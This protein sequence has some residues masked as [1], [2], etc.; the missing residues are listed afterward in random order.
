MIRLV[1]PYPISANEFKQPF[2]PKGSR[3]AYMYVTKEAKAWKEEAGLIAKVGGFREP[4]AKPVALRIV[5]L[6]RS[7]VQDGKNKGHRNGHVFDLDNV[8]KVSID[9]LNGIVFVDDR[10]V[11]RIVAEYGVE[12][13]RGALVVEVEEFV[14]PQAP[15][16]ADLQLPEAGRIASRDTGGLPF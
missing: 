2:V 6:H 16:F 3:R 7:V 5:L 9:G 13:P 15:L 8:L 11:K 10:Q 12:T 4:T 14:P 1:L